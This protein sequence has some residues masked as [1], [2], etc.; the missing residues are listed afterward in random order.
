MELA[1]SIGRYC[2]YQLGGSIP[3]D[4]H[5]LSEF[6]RGRALFASGL[7]VEEINAREAAGWTFR[8]TRI[9]EQFD[10]SAAKAVLPEGADLL[11]L[12]RKN[13]TLR[14]FTHA[15]RPTPE[16][17]DLVISYAPPTPSRG[18]NSGNET[19]SKE[20]VADQGQPERHERE[21]GGGTGKHN[22]KR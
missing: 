8:K 16:V 20:Q 6:L 12:L 9:S 11:L 5:S 22:R 17:D 13:G 18:S 2:V 14:F 3:D 7:G 21:D 4:N 15:S 19:S 1:P 10:F